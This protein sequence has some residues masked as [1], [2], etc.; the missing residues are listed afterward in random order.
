MNGHQVHYELF[1][2]RTP[3][4][5]WKLDMASESRSQVVESAELML[6]EGRVAAVRVTKETL[7]PETREFS[8]VTILTKGNTQEAPKRKV[9]EDREPLCVAPADLYS[10]HARDRI[11]QVLSGWLDRQRATP[12]ELLH[13]PDLVE[14]LDASGVEMQ[15]AIQ[16][17]AIPEAQARGLSVHELI[18]SFQSLIERAVS[19]VLADARRGSFP[20]LDREGFDTAVER[21]VDE[22]EAAYLLGAGVASSLAWERSWSDKITRL[23]DLAQ[24][25]PEKLGPR[26]LAFHV[27]E[28]PL[29]EILESRHA[30]AELLGQDLDLGGRLAAMTRLADNKTVD[31]LARI[32]PLVARHM[33]PLAGPAL[34]LAGWLAEPCFDHARAAVGRLILR[35]LKGPKRLRPT[36]PVQEIELLRALGMSLTAASGQLLPADNVQEAFIARSRMLVSSEFVGSLLGQDIA[37]R[38]ETERLIWLAENVIGAANKREAARY[39][40]AQLG[41]L[42]LEKD[43][44][45]GAETPSAKLAALAALQKSV[46]RVGLVP[47]DC[48]PLQARFGDL[49]GLIEADVKLTA[50][51]VQAEAPLAH[52]LTLLLRLAVAEAAPFGPAADRA[53]L[54]AMK[55]LRSKTALAEL[56]GAPDKLVEVREL[57][58]A[59]GLAA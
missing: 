22:P 8:S 18:R 47:E 27:L 33:P 21:L 23:L 39:L 28:Q 7:D 12:F 54:A 53:R 46:A 56:A 48:G 14:K 13:R 9:I 36:D 11:G 55:L 4:A 57:I 50:A 42:R 51:L 19:R 30:G 44:R 2:R 24:A 6:K 59:A 31:A 3:G 34:R 52:R 10:V 32:E 17:I 16:K 58:Q 40:S 38:E 49:G 20:N 25:A 41:S 5:P 35:E 29:A 26:R 15:H 1:V 45:N 37:A 43:L